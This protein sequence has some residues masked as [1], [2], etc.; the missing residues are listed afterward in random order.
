MQPRVLVTMLI[1][2]NATAAEPP[3]QTALHPV[4]KQNRVKTLL[5]SS[6]SAA[7][8]D[9]NGLYNPNACPF[10]ERMD[11]DRTRHMKYTFPIAAKKT[12]YDCLRGGACA[13]K[14]RDVLPTLPG[15]LAQ[16]LR[17]TF[18]PMFWLAVA[19]VSSLNDPGFRRFYFACSMVAFIYFSLLEWDSYLKAHR[20]MVQLQV[21]SDQPNRCGR[22]P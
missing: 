19:F 18:K 17:R 20:K 2:S 12:P 10:D 15:C 16:A 6:S 9:V 3:Q 22:F 8:A 14:D 1:Y 11:L 4:R 21:G 7:L 5:H 13:D